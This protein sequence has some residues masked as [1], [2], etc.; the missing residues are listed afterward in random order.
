MQRAIDSVKKS[1]MSIKSAA[2]MYN[3][4]CSTLQTKL[5]GSSSLM[6]RP[7]PAPTLPLY[8]EEACEKYLI[9]M[10]RRGFPLKINDLLILIS[11]ILHKSSHPANPFQNLG[12][13]ISKQAP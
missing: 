13:Q 1:D 8:I 3:V 9:E 11:E 12:L 6:C 2:K 10:A 4:P 7:G 5:S